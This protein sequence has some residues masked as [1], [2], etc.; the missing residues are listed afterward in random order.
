MTNE[1]D[2]APEPIRIAVDRLSSLSEAEVESG[3]KFV[4]EEFAWAVWLRLTTAH[5]SEF[6]PK[7][8][9]WVALLDACYPAGRV[10]I[11]P[12]QKN[13]LTHTF[14]HQDRNAPSSERHA[15]W[16][17]GKPCLDS[18]SQRLGRIAGGPEPK[19]DMDRRF[20]WHVERCL[21]WLRM[22]AESRLM[23][24]EDPFEIPHVPKESQNSEYIV[25]HDEG[26]DTWPTWKTRLREYGE[27][28]WGVIEGFEKTIIAE[29]F[30]NVY[31]EEIRVCRRGAQVGD[32]PWIG[33]WWL[34][35]SPIVLPP[36]YA[37]DMWS[38]LRRIGR[39]INLDVDTFIQWMACRIGGKKDVLV[40][41]GYPI[42]QTWNGVNVEI[43]WQAIK[44]PDVP[45]KIHPMKGF[46]N[47]RRGRKERLCRDIFGPSIKLSYLKTENWHPD[48]LQARGR[49]SLDVLR[50]PV[51]VIGAGALGAAIAELLARGGMNDILIIDND[52]L[53]AGNLVRHTLTG[54][55]LGRNKATA[56]AARLRAVA[57]MSRISAHEH[58]LLNEKK[59]RSLLE[60][61]DIVLDC[62]ANND[63]LRRLNQE[64]W[65]IPR[66]FL[67][68]SLG[69]AG[70]RLFLFGAY[71][72][73]FPFEK[74]EAAV[75]PWLDLER[76]EW[77]KSGETLEGP[78]CWSPLFPTRIDD[79]WLAAIATV[80]RLEHA[81]K[82][83]VWDDFLVFEKE[84]FA[85]YRNVSLEMSN[86]MDNLTEMATRND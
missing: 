80:R 75:R 38:E 73:S 36:W 27:V 85:G 78:G 31:G 53:E 12:N 23:I 18:P 35:P 49:F 4:K 56:T 86:P 6:V 43:H 41:L 44:S 54:A 81:V 8:T 57:P 83:N 74:F 71:S 2:R 59:L 76:S 42:P 39:C 37:P 19:D 40:L 69:F 45:A 26:R 82:H 24:T 30:L 10:R 51:A 84:E 34:W 1:L 64:W 70:K 29:K 60:E 79:V 25:I 16:R 55:D 72:C 48:R 21:E 14:P 61:F 46:R 52:K 65:P 58:C 15:I 67:S 7:D 20:F 68:A 33:Y 62:T 9:H 63:V 32:S 22:A 5:P 66:H 50:I 17:T 77:E 3:P 13:G 28:Y 47:N 11:Y